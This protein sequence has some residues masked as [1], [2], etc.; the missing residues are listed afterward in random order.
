[1]PRVC[2][3]RHNKRFCN[4]VFVDGHGESVLLTG[5]WNLKWSA[6]FDT[7]KVVSIPNLGNSRR[8][9]PVGNIR[10]RSAFAPMP[11]RRPRSGGA[12]PG[13]GRGQSGLFTGRRDAGGIGLGRGRRGAKNRNQIRRHLPRRAPEFG[14]GGAWNWASP[15]TPEFGL[16]PMAPLSWPRRFGGRCRGAARVRGVGGRRVLPAGAIQSGALPL[17][18]G[19]GALRPAE[20][21]YHYKL[22]RA[23]RCGRGAAVGREAPA[24]GGAP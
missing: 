20:P 2:I 14:F 8:R 17:P 12:S 21:Q 24:R 9:H 5:L 3:K 10:Q 13:V 23:A 19:R 7:S 4:V 6:V 18:G 11:L 15:G 22:A 16:P 1:M